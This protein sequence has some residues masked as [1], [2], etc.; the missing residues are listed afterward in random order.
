MIQSF[1]DSRVTLHPGDC[2]DVLKTLADNSIDAGV[3][4]PPYALVSIGKRFGAE[5]AAPAQEGA[6]GVYMRASAGFMGKSWDT[7]EAAFAV[8]FWREV[9]RVLKPGAHL[10]AF[11]GTRTHHRIWCAI[12]DAGFEVRDTLMWVYG[13][14][15]PKS[16][17]AGNGWGT[18]LKPAWEPIILARKPLIGTVVENVAR[19]GTGAINVGGCRVPAEARPLIVG[20]YKNTNNNT[21]AGRM[22]GSLQ[23]GSKLAGTTDIGRWPANLVHDGSDEV[24]EAFPQAKGQLR[25]VGPEHGAKPSVN[26]Y[27]DFGPREQFEPRNDSGSAARFFYCAKASKSDRN[28]GCDALPDTLGGIRSETS[29]QHITRRD[30]GDPG[31]VK[32]NHPTVKPTDLM[33]WLCRLVTPPNGLVLDPFTGSGSTGKAA[34][35]ESLRFLGIEKEANYVEIAKARIVGAKVHILGERAT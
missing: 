16:H 27:G 32:N 8:D 24:L 30:G 19:W 28:E 10:V 31:P 7:G 26:T 14:G 11:G 6:T 13:S 22:D 3:T 21:F 1:L 25:A 23:G 20:D 35:L 5:N 33:R 15:F 18:A 2:R 34:L 4:D 29:G 12:E 17:D 9:W